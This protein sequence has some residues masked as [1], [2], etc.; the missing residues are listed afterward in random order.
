MTKTIRV[1]DWVEFKYNDV[2][3]GGLVTEVLNATKINV[4]NADRAYRMTILV[5]TV[6]RINDVSTRGTE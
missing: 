4:I 3:I 5:S 6:V 2:E 1:N